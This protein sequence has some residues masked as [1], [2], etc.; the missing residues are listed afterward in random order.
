MSSEPAAVPRPRTAE[1]RNPL[2]R[3]RTTSTPTFCRIC[4]PCCGLIA[5]LEGDRLVRVRPDAEHVF[6]QGFACNKPQGLV[7]LTYG[8]D[9]I[10]TPMVRTG[11]P[12]AFT[13]VSWDEALT[14]CAEGLAS[15][16]DAHGPEAVAVLRGNPA[17]FDS[18]GVLW[19]EGFAA[20]LG[21][22]RTYSV[23]AE[24][25]ASR[26]TANEALYGDQMR[27]PL[28]DLWRTDLALILGANP[29]QA[30][31]TRMSEPQAREALDSIVARGGRVLI[32]D[33]CRTTTAERYEHVSIRPGTDP[34]FLMG[35][36]KIICD[37]EVDPGREACGAPSS[38]REAFADLVGS[39]DLD[40][41]AERCGSDVA[42]LGEVARAVIAAD[43]AVTLGGTG[44]CAQRF[45]TLTNILMDSLLAVTG[46]IDVVGG[47]LAGVGPFETTVAAPVTRTGSRRT[48]AEGRPEVAGALP[49][50]GLAADISHPGADRIR[51]LVI[52]GNN[53]VLSSGGGGSRLERALQ[54]LDFSVAIDVYVNETNR[55]A[56]VLLPTTVMYERDDYPLVS[57]GVQLRPTVYATGAVIEPVGECRPTWQIL[58]DIS[59]R[60][61]LGGSCPNKEVESAA[62]TRGHRPTPS[63]VLDA[64]FKAG[65]LPDM[66][67][68]ELV[69]RHTHGVALSDDL[70]VGRL[71]EVLRTPDGRVQLF[72]PQLQ[73]EVVNLRAYVEP[74]VEWPL[75][76]VGR[77]EKGSQNTWMHNSKAIYG[78][79]YQFRAH[80]NPIDAAACHAVEDDTVML[81]SVA[82]SIAIQISIVDSVMAGVVSVPHGWGHRGGSARHANAIGGVNS[83]EL[84][85]PNDVEALAGM[86][87][88]NG[89]PIRMERVSR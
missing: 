36:C 44:T 23:Y 20:A 40:E 2:L 25:A 88:L 21:I 45:G 87:I 78:D 77:R 26:L 85:D 82:G 3:E 67:F 86:S 66:T 74:D 76:L 18:G 22:S 9:R 79:A 37:G 70:P 63:D 53:S 12:G 62:E 55:Y 51:A 13:P 52:D 19:G 41:C 54:Q 34:W 32:V 10:T 42:T 29:L 30:R 84:V 1:A 81:T 65:A 72:S 11:A 33:P 5:E 56:D 59:R 73:S 7:H 57:S 35:L 4:E 39:F 28:P 80:V 89:I 6:S 27:S 71:T 75:R 14:R 16:R 50:A 60:L 69:S 48:R 83:N 58:D 31:S 15:V 8:S 47:L 61:G 49:S 64:M 17:H 24:D 38:G 46:N 68:R 43:S